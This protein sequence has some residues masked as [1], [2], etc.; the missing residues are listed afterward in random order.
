MDPSSASQP[1]RPEPTRNN[2]AGKA[3]RVGDKEK[4]EDKN[5]ASKASIA[6]AHRGARYKE[7]FQALREKFDQVTATHD[8]YQRELAIADEKVKRLQEECNL[9]LDAVDIAV[10]AQPSLLHYLSRDPIPPQYHS[11]TAVPTSRDTQTHSSPSSIESIRNQFHR[12]TEGGVM[13]PSPIMPDIGPLC[14]ENDM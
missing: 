14:A 1:V 9:L 12:A 13:P 8:Q 7:K 4:T 5:G 2:S 6:S 3:P 10:P 11:Y